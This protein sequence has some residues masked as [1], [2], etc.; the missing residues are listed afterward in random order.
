MRLPCLA[1]LVGVLML[2]GCQSGSQIQTRTH[3]FAPWQTSQL[4]V[5]EKTIE[6]TVAPGKWN[7]EGSPHRITAEGNHLTIRTTKANQ[8]AITKYLATVVRSS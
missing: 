1:C 6:T 5:W 3:T 8:D 4:P 2:V 7:Q